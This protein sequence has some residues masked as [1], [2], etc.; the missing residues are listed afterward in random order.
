MKTKCDICG[1][2]VRLHNSG[3]TS[4]YEPL[5]ADENARLREQLAQVT[6][7]RD[8]ARAYQESKDRLWRKAVVE[9]T[10]AR[11]EAGELK[12]IIRRCLRLAREHRDFSVLGFDPFWEAIGGVSGLSPASGTP[13]AL[14]GREDG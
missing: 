5:E 11:A 6:K 10:E 1:Q 13:A 7:E 14:E 8:D 4:F 2:A 3:V 9:R 12:A